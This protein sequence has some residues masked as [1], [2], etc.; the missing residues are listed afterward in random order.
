MIF[1]IPGSLNPNVQV[2]KNLHKMQGPG[3]LLGCIKTLQR[4][5]PKYC[6]KYEQVS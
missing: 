3:F 5:T 4:Q 6:I 1:F 2:V